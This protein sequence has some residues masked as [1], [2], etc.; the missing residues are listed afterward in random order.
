M[1]AVRRTHLKSG[2]DLKSWIESLSLPDYEKSAI[3]QTFD[4]CSR[5]LD[6]N[7]D[8]GIRLR[9][10]AAEMVGILLTLHLDLPTLQTAIIYPHVEEG[11]F[12]IDQ[13]R[14]E[15]GP[16]IAQ[17]L[18][19]TRDM[20][21]IKCLQNISNNE[22]PEQQVDK[23]RRMLISMIEDVR[24]V[25]VKLA[26]RIAVLREVKSAPEETRVLIAKE[27][28]TIYAPLAN[29]LGIG[30]L[31]WELED[32]AFRYLHPDIYKKIAHL[33]DEK[34]IDREAYI[35][36]FVSE[37]KAALAENGIKADVYGR[38]KHIYSIWRKMQKKHLEFTQLYDVRAVRII[39]EKIND[40]YA[41]LGVVHTHWHHIPSEFDDYIANPKP[42]GYKSIHTVVIGDEGKT[43]E[44][45]IRTQQMHRDAE[46]GVA[47][48][49][50][51]KEGRTGQSDSAYEERIAWLRKLLAW[52]EDM[53]ES[54]SL[55]DEFRSQVFEDRVYVFTPKGDVIDL[56]QGA[57]PLD[58]AYSIHTMVGHCCIGAKVNN[59]IVP[60]TY[61]LQTGEQVEIITQKEPN[62]SRDWLNPENG[63]IRTSRARAKIQ[64][65]FKKIDREHNITAGREIL[66]RELD[67]HGLDL[68]KEKT[69]EL[70]QGACPKYNVAQIDE[71]LA[72]IG[73][74]DV[75]IN[76]LI[77]SFETALKN[78]R[79]GE[80]A[81]REI[82][83]RY[84]ADETRQSDASAKTLP[85]KAG[86]GSEISVH[87]VGNLLTH[88]AKCCHPIPGDDIV[89]F[90]TVGRGISVH[91][92]DCPQFKDLSKGH[93][94][95]V[96]E[97]SWNGSY[98]K[99]YS[100]TVIIEAN[101][102]PG[103]LRDITTVLANQN[104]NVLGVRSKSNIARHS[105]VIEIDMEVYNVGDLSRV[106]TRLNQI[107]DVVSAKRL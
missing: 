47:A 12:T 2:F 21:A 92:T 17:L 49:W 69:E 79:S 90:I 71:L 45:Q 88:L 77:N 3:L 97:A 24:S 74:G 104:V 31:K 84:G 73:A 14:D 13:A 65:W 64:S 63:Y 51:Y 94:E 72:K 11:H 5:H 35:N 30:Q 78:S 48:H 1:V 54:G 100:L 20:E 103:L 52:Q 23:V 96:V 106:L 91:R 41:A 59:K 56:P 62:P 68:S 58:L 22:V 32:L 9:K 25:C 93:P 4:Y 75:K 8:D 39:V 87:G 40:C 19:G 86:P 29:R 46:L 76:Q 66:A 80:E 101:D 34:R 50:K 37:L 36:K 43:V 60:F 6:E 85:G 82:L 55:I 99:G 67:R 95:R 33:L 7:T 70:L 27:I 26:E 102:R 28:S 38:P 53:V 57:T 98:S 44:I 89:G 105:A 61:T 107:N 18:S 10:R 42:N 16:E 83:A 81:D 15:F